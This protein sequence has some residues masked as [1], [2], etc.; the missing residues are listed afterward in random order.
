MF[1]D[2]PTLLGILDQYVSVGEVVLQPVVGLVCAPVYLKY[3]FFKSSTLR[4]IMF[5][6]STVISIST[7]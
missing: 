2:E 3:G 6:P 4:E 7:S 1:K 5:D